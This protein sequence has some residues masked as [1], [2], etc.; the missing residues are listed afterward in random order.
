MTAVFGCAGCG[1]ALTAPVSRVALPV[2]AHHRYGHE[3]LPPFMEPGTFA[4]DPEPFGPPWRPWDEVGADEAEARGVY[5]PVPSLS[6]GPRGAVAIAP[7]D[8]RGTVLLPDRC[9]GY[10]LGLDGRDGPNLACTRCGRAVATR[11]DD[12]SYWQAVWLDPR[13]VRRITGDDPPPRALG[14][15]TLPEERP[16]EPSGAWSPLWEAAV[17]AALA[18]LLA[19]SSGARVDLP[20]GLVAETFGPALDDLLPSAAPPAKSLALAGPGRSP[21]ADIALVPRHPRTGETWPY[22]GRTVPLAAEV[23]T[24]LAL[25]HDRRPVPGAGRMSDDAR[26]DEPPPLLPSMRFRPDRD[27]F[28]RTLARLPEVCEPWLRAIYDRVRNRTRAYP[29]AFW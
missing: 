27:L 9:G 12:C 24:Y 16:V 20:D 2:H 8:A 14:W 5:A 1:A 19:V 26:R 17:S 3:F 22:A 10:C 21:A 29:D 4:V 28:L 13:A 6:Y 11:V 7:G 25:R 23:W 15:E 18:H